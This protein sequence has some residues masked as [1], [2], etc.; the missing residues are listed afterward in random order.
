[1][2]NLEKM[3]KWMSDRQGKVSYSMTNRLGPNSY[4][5]SSAVFNAMIAGEVLPSNTFIGNTETLYGLEGSVLL[6]IS[7]SEVKRGDVFVSGVKGQSL[8]SGGHTGIFLDNSTI[9]HCTY[10]YGN[11]NMAVTPA[12]QWMGDYSGLPVYY[13]RIKGATPTPPPT[14][15]NTHVRHNVVTFWYDKT[16]AGYTQILNYVKSKNFAHKIITGKEGRAM[17]SIGTFSQNSPGKWEL[18][19]FLAQNS[20][21]YTLELVG[22]GSAAK[23]GETKV[24]R[25]TNKHSVITY[26]YTKN[27]QNYKTVKKFIDEKGWKYTETTSADGR[28]KFTVSPFTQTSS[29]KFALTEFLGKS[30]L[31]YTIELV[32]K[33]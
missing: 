16:S 13:Y 5:C 9:I 4:D 7:R 15:P 25:A 28:A 19:K 30:N 26:W 11:N 27:A 31:N 12:Y 20:K 32:D 6:P 14:I 17:I 18:E 33:K 21:N 2:A 3:I 29:N 24:A 10:G 1:M 23:E 8:G 22:S